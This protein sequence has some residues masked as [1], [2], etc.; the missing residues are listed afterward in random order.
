MPLN[1]KVFRQV[2]KSALMETPDGKISN[3]TLQFMHLAATR[4]GSGGLINQSY[5]LGRI[6]GYG[7]LRW[8]TRPWIHR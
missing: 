2:Y 1:Y 7:S 5:Y 4:C 6:L 3:E 8:Y